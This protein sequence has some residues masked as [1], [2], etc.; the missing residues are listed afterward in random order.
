MSTPVPAEPPD[1]SRYLDL[2]PEP[3]R[4]SWLGRSQPLIAGVVVLVLLAVGAVAVLRRSSPSATPLP[5]T[6]TPEAPW[7]GKNSHR[8]P[9]TVTPDADIADGQTVTIS[10]SGFPVGKQVAAVVCTIDAG[11]KGVDACDISTSSFMAGTNVVVGKDGRFTFE[12]VMH[13]HVTIGG[14]AV[15]CSVG[16]VDPAIYRQSVVQF[17]PTVRITTPGAFSCLVGVGAIDNYDQSGGALIAFRGETYRPFEVDGTPETT[18]STGPGATPTTAAT[19]VPLSTS[20]TAPTTPNTWTC[21]SGT[22]S[23]P[24]GTTPATTSDTCPP[25]SLAPR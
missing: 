19:E 15:D 5:G 2:G 23:V 8:L 22:L 18:T 24:A 11:S 6:V 7:D 3:P 10:G 13:S 14:K 4:R 1:D 16:N 9:I 17:G 21:S 12:Y 20:T 25:P